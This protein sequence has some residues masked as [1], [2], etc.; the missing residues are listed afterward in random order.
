[1]ARLAV[2]MVGGILAAATVGAHALAVYL[3]PI[4]RAAGV[5]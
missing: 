4:L 3:E 1:M 2:I 5:E